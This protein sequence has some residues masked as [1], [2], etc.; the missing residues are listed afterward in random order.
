MGHSGD[1]R[2][3]LGIVDPY[4]AP[5]HELGVGLLAER[6]RRK[7]FSLDVQLGDRTARFGTGPLVGSLAT[8]VETFVR[9]TGG[10]SA[11]PGRFELEGVEPGDLVLFG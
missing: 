11:D 10:R 3:A 9:L 4:A 1:I 5:S 7:E 6:S 8:D 2:E